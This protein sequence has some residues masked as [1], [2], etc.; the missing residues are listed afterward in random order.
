MRVRGLAITLA[1]AALATAVWSI[2][3][4]AQPRIVRKHPAFDQL[5]PANAVLEKIAE[6]FNWIEGPA[7]NRKESF[8]L[9]SDIPANSVYRWRE[10]G[11][12]ELFLKPSGYYGSAPFTG[13]EPGSNGLA[14]DAE[15]RLLLA[16]HGERRVARIEKDGKLTVLADRFEGKR[17]NSPNDMAIHANGDIYFTDPPYGLPKTFSDPGRE[18]DFC[19][20]YRVNTKG[21][22][23]LLVR[24]IK[25][26]NG[27]AF[28]PDQKTLYVASSDRTRAV[29]MAYD[30][31]PDGTLVNGRVFFDATEWTNTASGA[32]DGMKVDVRGNLFA[33]GPGGLHVFS[34]QGQHLGSFETGGL[35][36]NCAWGGDGSTLYMTTDKSLHRVK[37]STRG[38]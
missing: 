19:G 9:F 10:S 7:W 15:G 33:S 12:A 32:P 20:V 16:Q 30:V 25:A 3:Q 31:R 11:K 37:L 28:S 34:P 2:A 1:A 6:G 13:R 14:Y 27:I 23:T 5:V 36:S 24:D 38:Y 21:Q 29:W 22:V 8:L 26:P 17:F 35:I 18:L 4:G